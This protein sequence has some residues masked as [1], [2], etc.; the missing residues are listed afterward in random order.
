MR[1]F[2]SY[3]P[4]EKRNNGQ[5]VEF[6]ER[7]SKPLDKVLPFIININ[8]IFVLCLLKFYVV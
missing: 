8:K 6:L 1:E 5:I 2:L 4:I 7:E 3:S